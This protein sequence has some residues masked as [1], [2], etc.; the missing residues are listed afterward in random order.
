M[1]KI[2]IILIIFVTFLQREAYAQSRPEVRQDT[3]V[4]CF[5][6]GSYSFMP[7]YK[8]NKQTVDLLK[9]Y[10]DKYREKIENGE[11]VIRVNTYSSGNAAPGMT[12]Q[13]LSYMRSFRLKSYMILY[14]GMKESFF[15]TTNHVGNMGEYRDVSIL[16]FIVNPDQETKEN[17]KPETEKIVAEGSGSPTTEDSLKIKAEEKRIAVAE[18][19][20]LE[21]EKVAR[22]EKAR[23]E[24]A[25]ERIAAEKAGQEAEKAKLIAEQETERIRK[26]ILE[27]EAAKKA[28][29]KRI[30]TEDNQSFNLRTNLLQWILLTPNIGVEYIFN[31][32][33]SVLLEANF[34]HWDWKDGERHYRLWSLSPSLRYKI[35]PHWY[36]GIGYQGGEFGYKFGKEGKQGG[37][38][39][40]NLQGGYLLVIND[41]ISFDFGLGLG[42]VHASYDKYQ[43]IEGCN[44]NTETGI[45]KNYFGPTRI[46]VTLIWSI[47]NFIAK[48]K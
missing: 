13:R 24:A 31:E 9:Q 44:V 46:D 7:Y 40:I 21:A 23:Q 4:F 2:F 6:P 26:Q 20:R 1:R 35:N 33:L 32:R 29:Q 38:H 28:E 18:I 47:S 37:S 12:D 15:R 14:R 10:T 39:T 42:Y 27:E 8:Q 30:T 48:K 16:S 41:R 22:Q 25:K 5:K 43:R 19:A 11:Y 17:A 36:T 45:K 34:T 3:V